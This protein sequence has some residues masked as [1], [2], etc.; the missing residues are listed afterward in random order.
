MSEFKQVDQYYDGEFNTVYEFKTQ[1]KRSNERFYTNAGSRECAIFVP[2]IDEKTGFIELEVDPLQT[3]DIYSEIQSHKDSVDLHK[4]VDRYRAGETD[5]LERIKG[6]YAD[7]T[8]APKNIHEFF[9]LEERAHA[10][11]D[12]LPAELRQN[13]DNSSIQFIM[14]AGTDDWFKKLQ[15]ASEKVIPEKGESEE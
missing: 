2:K 13:F 4:I 12:R 8:N 15:L 3:K 5:V 11:F 1:Y 10:V 7:L 14:S 6:F 9:E